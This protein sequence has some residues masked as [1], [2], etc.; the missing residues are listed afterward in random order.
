VSTFKITSYQSTKVYKQKKNK[1][2][3]YIITIQKGKGDAR[4]RLTLDYEVSANIPTMSH[5]YHAQFIT[6]ILQFMNLHKCANWIDV[7]K[8]GNNFSFIPAM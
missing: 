6:Q 8:P 2:K 3:T 5:D 1:T 4:Q 7:I